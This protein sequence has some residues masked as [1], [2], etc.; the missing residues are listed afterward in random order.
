MGY[1]INVNSIIYFIGKK[2][3]NQ[4]NQSYQC[5]ANGSPYCSKTLPSFTIKYYMKYFRLTR[6]H[7]SCYIG[8]MIFIERFL[9]NN[10]KGISFIN[11]WNAHRLVAIAFYIACK[12]IEDVRFNG[13]CFSKILG[14]T[15]DELNK[16]EIEFLYDIEWNIFVSATDY[17]KVITLH[18]PPKYHSQLLKGIFTTG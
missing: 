7:P 18:I 6:C 10:S 1:L 15:M 12:T 11:K 8:M 3:D 5:S 14:I 17:I 13:R 2:Y 4:I 9:N 16:L